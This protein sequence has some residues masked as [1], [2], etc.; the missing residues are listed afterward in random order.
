MKTEALDVADIISSYPPKAR[1]KIKELRH[2]ILQ[3]AKKDDRIGF[4]QETVRWGQPSYITSETKSGS[5]VRFDLLKKQPDKIALYFHC[6]TNL[7]PMFKNWY[8]E[9]Q[10]MGNRAIILDVKNRL[11]KQKLEKCILAAF[12]YNLNQT[13]KQSEGRNKRITRKR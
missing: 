3:A 4:L 9:L 1:S 13:K 12:T 10:Y 6:Q 8:P 11:P 7:V 2:L 5:L